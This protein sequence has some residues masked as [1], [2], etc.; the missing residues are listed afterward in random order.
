MWICYGVKVSNPPSAR[1]PPTP[2]H[3]LTMKARLLWQR[4]RSLS[5]TYAYGAWS[6][7]GRIEEEQKKDGEVVGLSMAAAGVED[8]QMKT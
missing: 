8:R 6:N 1:P 5:T 4:H 7:D 2:F 3:L